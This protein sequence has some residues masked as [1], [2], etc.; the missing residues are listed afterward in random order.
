MKY[1]KKSLL[2][3]VVASL[4]AVL[5]LTRGADQAAMNSTCAWKFVGIN[6]EY[7]RIDPETIR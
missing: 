7:D 2:S 1:V 5:L 4:L 6:A 3:A